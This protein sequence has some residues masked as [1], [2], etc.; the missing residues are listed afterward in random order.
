MM[1]WF[2]DVLRIILIHS[3]D[4]GRNEHTFLGGWIDRYL[5]ESAP[6]KVGVLTSTLLKVFEK[7]NALQNS[8]TIGITHFYILYLTI[9]F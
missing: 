6:N 1:T 5:L 7:C 9:D 3:D 2:I 8:N 4:F